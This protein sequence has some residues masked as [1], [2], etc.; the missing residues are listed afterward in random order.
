MPKSDKEAAIKKWNQLKKGEKDKAVQM[1]EAYYNH[2]P[3][4]K[5]C[6]KARTYLNDKNFNDEFNVPAKDPL[7]YE[8]VNPELREIN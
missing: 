7:Y 3:D 8:S 2:L 4:K 5:Y 1:I 6:K